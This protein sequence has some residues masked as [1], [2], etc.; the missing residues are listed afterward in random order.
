MLQ[1]MGLQRDG[2]DC[3]TELTKILHTI[4][5]C[6]FIFTPSVLIKGTYSRFMLSMAAMFQ[7]VSTNTV[8][9]GYTGVGSWE[10]WSQER[11]LIQVKLIALESFP[12][13]VAT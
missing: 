10:S 11:S 3:V 8:P 2:H 13:F 7:K 5:R 6:G 9:R 12:S 1:S 4:L